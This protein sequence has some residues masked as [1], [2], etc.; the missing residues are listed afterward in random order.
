MESM[1]INVVLDPIDNNSRN[2]LQNIFFFIPQNKFG[3]TWRWVNDPRGWT[4]PLIGLKKKN[5]MHIF[6]QLFSNTDIH[7]FTH[8]TMN[9]TQETGSDYHRNMC[10]SLLTDFFA[11]KGIGVPKSL[12]LHPPPLSPFLSLFSLSVIL[13][14]HSSKYLSLRPNQFSFERSKVSRGAGHRFT[15]THTHTHTPHTHTISS[16]GLIW[17]IY[18]QLIL[19]F[20]LHTLTNSLSL[21]LSH[22]LNLLLFLWPVLSFS[23]CSVHVQTS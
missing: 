17:H 9:V 2:I 1:E 16:A 21:S 20:L 13:L 12:P 5:S 19:C 15:H 11:G 10:E 8:H 22:T 14:F 7:T 23:T 4:I 6:S 18:I 3:A